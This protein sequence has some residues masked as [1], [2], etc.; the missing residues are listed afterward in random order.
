VYRGGDVYDV[1][2]P[3][4][5]FLY[6]WHDADGVLLYVGITA[7][8]ERREAHHSRRAWWA[9]YAVTCTF[10]AEPCSHT[11]QEAEVLERAVI[12][13]ERPVFNLRRSTTPLDRVADY[14]VLRGSTEAAA[15]KTIALALRSGQA[16]PRPRRTAK[17]IRPL[18]RVPSPAILF[19][20]GGM[21]SDT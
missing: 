14:L 13:Q 20:G 8:P 19:G 4:P 21:R 2:A 12:E 5:H 9:H 1:Y 17:E 7:T 10:D 18:G 11:R 3:R 6:R 16:D 15:W